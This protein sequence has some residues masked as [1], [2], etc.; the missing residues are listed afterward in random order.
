[1]DDLSLGGKEGGGILKPLQLKIVSQ[2]EAVKLLSSEH[3]WDGLVSIGPTDPKQLFRYLPS[4]Y[5]H[6]SMNDLTPWE[7]KNVDGLASAADVLK[8]VWFGESLGNW[9]RILIHCGAGCC[10]S[11]AAAMALLAAVGWT[12]QAAVEKVRQIKGGGGIPNGWLLKLSDAIFGTDL[13]GICATSGNTKWTP[14]WLR[15]AAWCDP[16]ERKRQ[17]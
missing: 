5:V 6:L 12:D 10:R 4:H 11:T 1:M 9:S 7:Q 16:P 13:F 2:D 17:Q 3:K 8:L 14:P 15:G